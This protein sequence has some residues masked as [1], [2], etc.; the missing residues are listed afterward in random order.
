MNEDFYY[1]QNLKLGMQPL[2]PGMVRADRVLIYAKRE[3]EN[4]L[5][6]SQSSKNKTAGDFHYS[7]NRI[8][9]QTGS[10]LNMGGETNLASSLFDEI[11]NLNSRILLKDF[12]GKIEH[13]IVKINTFITESEFEDSDELRKRIDELEKQ[14]GISTIKSYSVEDVKKEKAIFIIMPF[15]DSFEDVWKGAIE[16]SVTAIHYT[17]IRADLINRSSNITDDIIESIKASKLVIVDVTDF[18][19]NVMFELGYAYA[20]DKPHIIISQTVEN[21]P[22]DIRNIRTILYKN[23]WTGI[24]TLRQKLNEYLKELPHSQRN[25]KP[26]P[27]KRR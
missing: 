4:L 13:L 15:R 22:F 3:L 9:R 10:L 6:R 7:L 19:P 25:T 26:K 16:K 1:L 14:L 20:L 5:K 24:E 21:L 17:P 23:T 27:K 11:K 8:I 18:N 2:V 12:N